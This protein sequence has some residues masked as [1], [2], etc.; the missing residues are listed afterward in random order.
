MTTG[1]IQRLTSS[2]QEQMELLSVDTPVGGLRVPDP[3]SDQE[4]RASAGAG[5]P[6][7]ENEEDSLQEQT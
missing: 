6:S 3:D 7:E 1:S 2:L 4:L 5:L